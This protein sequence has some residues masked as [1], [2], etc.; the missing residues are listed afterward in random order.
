MIPQKFGLLFMS[1]SLPTATARVN[2]GQI[3]SS[4]ITRESLGT[5]TL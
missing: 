2:R 3:I 1:K 5:L 4:D